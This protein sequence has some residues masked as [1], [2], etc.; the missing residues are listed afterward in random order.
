MKPSRSDFIVGG[1][2]AAIAIGFFGG[3]GLAIYYD[4]PAWLIVSLV[5]FCVM[6]AG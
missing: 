2:L 3:I 6:Y 5:S 1:V 4:N